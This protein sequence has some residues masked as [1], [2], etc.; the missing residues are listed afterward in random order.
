MV[1]AGNASGICDGGAA[2][3]IASE[4]AVNKH[5]LKPL[6]RIVSYGVTACEP[7]IMGIGPV[8]AI[9][10]AL[11]RAGKSIADMDIIE[12]NEASPLSSCRSRKNSSSLMIRR[13]CLVVRSRSATPWL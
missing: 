11:G 3:V 7:S 12:V 1:S 6:A 9:K 13:T 2:N 10:M 4:E 8:E 5:S